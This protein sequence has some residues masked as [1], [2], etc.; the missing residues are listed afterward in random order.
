[1]TTTNN[2][3]FKGG[4]WIKSPEKW[5]DIV[6]IMPRRKCII[7]TVNEHGDK[8]FAIKTAYD[9]EMAFNLL[10][11]KVD[12]KFYPDINL[13][14]RLDGRLPKESMA[15]VEAQERVLKGDEIRAY[16]ANYNKT[17]LPISKYRWKPEDHID[18]TFKALKTVLGIDR[19]N[20]NVKIEKGIATI[21]DKS[22]KKIAKASPNSDKGYNYVYILPRD[23]EGSS[24]RLCVNYNGE[25]ESRFAPADFMIFKEHFMKNVKRD[26]G[27]KRPQGEGY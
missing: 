14:S 16:F 4:F 13:K 7:D 23:S 26:I 21:F 9:K 2:V 20:C 3:T 27:R 22:G 19:N 6:K 18:Q 11:K 15:V 1:M 10:R 24:Q 8:F 25:I 12:Y 17:S 5:N